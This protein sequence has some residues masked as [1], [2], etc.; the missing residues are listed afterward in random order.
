MYVKGKDILLL[1][2]VIAIG[3]LCLGGMLTCLKLFLFSFFGC[4]YQQNSP[5]NLLLT[6]RNQNF[7]LDEGIFQLDKMD[8]TQD[9]VGYAHL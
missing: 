3:C 7:S 9:Y 2:Y 1:S 8:G 6:E 4:S 5:C